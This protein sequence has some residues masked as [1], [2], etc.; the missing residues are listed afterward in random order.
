MDN[1][2]VYAIRGDKNWQETMTKSQI[3]DKIAAENSE[4]AQTMTNLISS[5]EATIETNIRIKTYSNYNQVPNCQ[6]VGDMRTVAQNMAKPGILVTYVNDSN[7]PGGG[8]GVLT[9][10]T[11][12]TSN[13]AIFMFE[14]VTSQQTYV[15]HFFAEDSSN[16]IKTAMTWVRVLDSDTTLNHLTFGNGGSQNVTLNGD[17][18]KII[19]AELPETEGDLTI[20]ISAEMHI[21]YG[22]QK[23]PV[24]V[25][26][27][28]SGQG[29]NYDILLYNPSP[30]M[31]EGTV[32]WRPI[33][34]VSKYNA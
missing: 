19:T 12:T 34:S 29:N 33:I 1:D 20:D 3:E 32:S 28:L 22:T 25:N 31:I 6:G 10:R 5:V 24:V 21:R 4:L 23:M 15:C 7:L 8:N 17:E 26:A 18:T 13:T 2:K 14:S 11:N 30:N 9:I 27:S 16:W